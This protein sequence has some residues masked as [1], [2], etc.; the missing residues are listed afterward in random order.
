V[1]WRKRPVLIRLGCVVSGCVPEADYGVRLGALLALNDVEL[2]LIALFQSL[3][4]VELDG[5]IVNE[6]IRPVIASNESVAL[7][8][9][10]P[11][12]LPFELSHRLLLSCIER[13]VAVSE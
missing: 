11:L 13:E 8:V 6:Y 2:N 4:P 5:G 10:K 7:G 9:V 12:D 3:V 1:D